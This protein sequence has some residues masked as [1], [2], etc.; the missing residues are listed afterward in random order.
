MKWFRFFLPVLAALTLMPASSFADGDWLNL[1]T[2]HFIV[3]YK[4]GHEWQAWEALKNLEHFRPQV[5][6]LTGND[7][8]PLTAISIQDAGEFSNGLT[9]PVDYN[10]ELFTEP[11]AAS[12][13]LADE[14]WWALVPTH[15]YTHMCHLSR[16]FGFPGF[17]S[18]AFG[19]FF[20]PNNELPSWA[21]EGYAVYSE[22]QVSPYSGRLSD[23]FFDDYLGVSEQEGRFPSLLKATF[24]PLE[25][26]YDVMYEAGSGFYRYL[27]QTYGES[28]FADFY[29]DYDTNFLSYA[30]GLFPLVGLDAAA[31]KNFKDKSLP[32]LWK[33]FEDSVKSQGGDFEP[34]GEALSHEGWDLEGLAV[35]D[36]H[37][38]YERSYPVKTG[39]Y[40]WFYFN[41]IRDRDTRTGKTRVLVST[42]T[43]FTAPLRIHGNKLYYAV[44]EVKPGYDNTASYGYFSILH[45]KDLTSGKDQE[46]LRGQ[47]RGF[48]A[49]PDSRILFSTDR[50]DAFGSELRVYDPASGTEQLLFKLDWLVDEIAAEEGHIVVTA[51]KSWGLY[52]L[53]A[54]DLEKGE[55]T[56]LVPSPFLERNPQ[57]AGDKLYF[58]ANFGRKYALYEYDFNDSRLSRLT[59]KGYAAWPAVDEEEGRVYF[60]GLNSWGLDLYSRDY[61]PQTYRLAEAPPSAEPVYD[62][63]EDQVQ[64]GGYGDNLARLNP[65]LFHAPYA[66]F[67]NN[68]QLAGLA[69]A[70]T[71]ALYQFEY[72]ALPTYNFLDNRVE[73]DLAMTSLFFAPFTCAVEYF[74]I[75]DNTL[76]LQ[77]AY[78]LL[79]QLSPGM[80]QLEVGTNLDFG[81]TGTELDPF[82]NVSFS[83]PGTGASAF[84]TTPVQRDDWGSTRNRTAAYV[85]ASLAQYLPQSQLVLSGIWMEDLQ[86]TSTVFPTLRGYSGALSGTQ[87]LALSEDYSV[88]LFQIRDGLWN[89]SLY[90]QD[91]VLDLF[92]DQAFDNLGGSQ[93]AYGAALH[94]ET[95]FFNT[96]T[97]YPEDLGV[98]V[99]HNDSGENRVEGFFDV[100]DWVLGTFARTPLA[101]GAWTLPSGAPPLDKME[102]FILHPANPLF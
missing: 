14:N 53:C 93:W 86:A 79:V 27:A 44:S 83:Y 8:P 45:E 39:T 40:S 65:K 50:A 41:E 63:K 72:A 56:P 9:D 98:R 66:Y 101:S 10:I 85:Y 12:G 49:L 47:I 4:P 64:K 78:P 15:E 1:K 96:Y 25:Y 73:A 57:L 99:S 21:E 32:T 17:L 76:F 37:L 18:Q 87:G 54:L 82:L 20:N 100:Y 92:S 84:L 3:F 26:P 80:T 70:G 23:G 13:F 48:D 5:M 52:N 81:S 58:N 24:V 19:N 67:D 31:E 71:D 97:G 7:D 90:F 91:L 68:H 61:D 88:P 94:L 89:P 33:D 77:G 34:D 38:Y 55:L 42:T 6:K 22:S 62:L 36:G 74:G 51:Q 28:K 35:A 75:D 16:S 30:S 29:Q 60:S 59:Q 46:L 69:F 102:R 95:K 2:D 43:S 11:P